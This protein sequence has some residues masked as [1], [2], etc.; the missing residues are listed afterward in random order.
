MSF[1]Q[2]NTQN[3]C[4]YKTKQTLHSKQK[5]TQR[6]KPTFF[7]IEKNKK[8]GE[9]SKKKSKIKNVQTFNITFLV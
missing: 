4:C 3:S 8:I 7:S 9:L 1:F 2:E 6:Y 5:K